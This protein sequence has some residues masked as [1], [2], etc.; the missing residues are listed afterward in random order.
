MELFAANNDGTQ[1]VNLSGT[2]AAN[3]NVLDV[4][5]SPNKK[6]AVFIADKVTKG[7]PELFSVPAT[8]GVPTR[9]SIP[10]AAGEQIFTFECSPNSKRIAYVAI[11]GGKFEVHIVN[12]DGTVDVN[13]GTSVQ[14][15]SYSSSDIVWSPNGNKLL[16]LMDLDTPA[17]GDLFVVDGNGKHRKNIS[18]PLAAAGIV[19]NFVWAPNSSRVAFTAQK[20]APGVTE[21]FVCKPDGSSLVKVSGP[22]VM[23]GNA[24][25]PLF[26]PNSKKVAY[27]ADQIT[28]GVFE[29]FV[30]T[31]DGK[32]NV[33]VSPPL[34]SKQDA[35]NPIWS[36]N[37][38]FIAVAVADTT[39]NAPIR[40]F[41]AKADGSSTKE[42]GPANP[43]GAT[44]SNVQWSHDNKFL[45]YRADQNT[46]FKNEIMRVEPDGS[47]LTSLVDSLF[48]SGTVFGFSLSRNS[49]RMVF[50]ARTGPAGPEEA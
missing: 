24:Q 47:E 39:V 31:I 8:G 25:E 46:K 12:P 30:S 41:S 49:N 18:A 40:L 16:F 17:Q 22:M 45:Y 7:I 42:I 33:K 29:L 14:L 23:K 34:S 11:V 1:I 21:L 32:K 9:I 43:V 28:D 38:N 37:S 5:W 10:V 13:V 26:S 15:I 35:L 44:M 3:S 20:D 2:M 19:A 48:A 27:R 50:A 36:P 4:D 6:F